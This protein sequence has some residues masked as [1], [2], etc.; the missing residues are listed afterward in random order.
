MTGPR[1]ERL[2]T[3]ACWY[4]E[5]SRPPRPPR[6]APGTHGGLEFAPGT[7]SGFS[8]STIAIQNCRGQF[9]NLIWQRHLAKSHDLGRQPLEVRIID[10]QLLGDGH[11]EGRLGVLPEPI[12]VQ[13]GARFSPES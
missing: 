12:E 4:A 1:P 9:H 3:T 11:Q 8:S 7:N 6:R 13:F 2:V 5:Q 10:P